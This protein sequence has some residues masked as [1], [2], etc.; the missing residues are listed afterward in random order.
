MRPLPLLFVF[1]ALTIHANCSFIPDFFA[2]SSSKNSLI[3]AYA[4]STGEVSIVKDLEGYYVYTD[5]AYSTSPWLVGPDTVKMSLGLSNS[6]VLL[7]DYCLNFQPYNCD[8]YHCTKDS[9]SPQTVNYPYFISSVIQASASVYLDYAYWELQEKALLATAC[10]T[11]RTDSIGTSRSG[12]IGLG[13]DGSSRNNF[14]KNN[15]FSILWSS[16]LRNGTL[17]FD[18]DDTYT[19][20]TEGNLTSSANWIVPIQGY[21]QMSPYDQDFTGSLAFDINADALGFPLQ[22]FQYIVQVIVKT[23]WLHPITCTNDTF[24][25]TCNY[26]GYVKNLPTIDLGTGQNSIHITFPPEIY[27]LNAKNADDYVYSITL[28]LKALDPLSSGKP[29][30]TSDFGNTIIVDARSMSPYY[31]VF[32]ATESTNMIQLYQAKVRPDPNNPP[33]KWIYVI[34]GIIILVMVIACCASCFKKKR[35][36]RP[37]TQTPLIIGDNSINNAGPVVTGYDYNYQGGVQ[38]NNYYQQQQPQ[39]TIQYAP[40]AAPTGYEY[41]KQGN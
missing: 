18:V 25:P 33:S 41:A 30:V 14:L 16:D 21:I 17:R 32:N 20:Y 15:L 40:P 6:H 8:K 2:H 22:L 35:T 23:Q 5:L 9:G 31:I 11:F 26:T 12:I 3:N 28:N 24:Q 7:I 1:L 4:S 19:Y 36:V 10:S 37:V 34:I 39:G 38:N 27:V 13:T 29:Y